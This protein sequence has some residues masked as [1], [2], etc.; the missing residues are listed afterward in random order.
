MFRYI[1]NRLAR[2]VV[3]GLAKLSRLRG[4]VVRQDREGYDRYFISADIN[5]RTQTKFVPQQILSYRKCKSRWGRKKALTRL[6]KYELSDNTH[7]SIT[8]FKD[9]TFNERHLGYLSY[10][11]E[12]NTGRYMWDTPQRDN[13]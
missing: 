8:D 5:Y 1:E 10:Y 2:T 12:A 9:D 4:L 3:R 11:R 7:A 6:Q 13:G